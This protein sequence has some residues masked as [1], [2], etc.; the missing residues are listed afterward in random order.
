MSVHD[1]N[2]HEIYR[3]KKCGKHY[4]DDERHLCET[5]IVN[6]KSGKRY[7]IYIGRSNKHYNLDESIFCNPYIIMQDGLT[8][9]M[10]IKKFAEYA[11]INKK[12]MESLY[13][14]DGKTLGCWCN[15]PDED[16]HGRIL[17]ELREKQKS[18]MKKLN[19]A[20][21]GSRTFT[22]KAR[23]Y[24]VLDKNI[25]KIAKIVSGGA[26]GADLFAEEWAIERKIPTE[27]FR[28]KWRD[29]NG[30]FD[31][32]AGFKR[33]HLIIKA[34]DKVLCFWDGK[35]AGTKNSLDWAEKLGKPVI[36]LKFTP[37]PPEEPKKEE[38]VNVPYS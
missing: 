27:I 25:H 13:L 32:G 33:N 38:V 22:D 11:P 34:A 8:R 17:I 37:E 29:E 35:S 24:R 28:P 1:E 30:V 10:A 16:C 21:I 2:N 5:R 26:Q 4:P 36:L 7:D 3:C 20:V 15:Y 31:K 6:I 12:L 14:I 18:E 9:E 19:I 23:L